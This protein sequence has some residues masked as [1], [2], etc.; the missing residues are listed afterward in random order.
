MC[1]LVAHCHAEIDLQTREI[2]NL[3][4]HPS[5][6]QAARAKLE[7]VIEFLKRSQQEAP[8]KGH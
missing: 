8:M 1:H 7:K 3:I 2:S 6:E 4:C 5:A